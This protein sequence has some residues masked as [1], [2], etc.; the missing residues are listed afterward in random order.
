MRKFCVQ[1]RNDVASETARTASGGNS[2]D[3]LDELREM[4]QTTEKDPDGANTAGIGRR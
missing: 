1:Y 4:L 3:P 2:A